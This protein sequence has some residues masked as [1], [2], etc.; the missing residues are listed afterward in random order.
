MGQENYDEWR[1]FIRNPDVIRAM[2]EDCRAGLTIDRQHEEADR[3][4]GRRL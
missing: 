1:A 2:L 4:A 3:V